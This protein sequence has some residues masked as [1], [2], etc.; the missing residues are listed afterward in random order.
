MRVLLDEH[1]L[2]DLAAEFTGHDVSTVRAEGWEGLSNGE[3]LTAS[4]I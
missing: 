2:V 1:L 3:L 4:R